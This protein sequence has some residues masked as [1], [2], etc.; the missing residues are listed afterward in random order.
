[1]LHVPPSVAIYV[2][3]R[4]ADLRKGFD[5]LSGII[6]Q[7]FQADPLDG[8]LFLFFNRRRD[9]LKILHFDG[10]GYWLYYK[11]LEAG[12]F[13]AIAGEGPRVQIDATA[14]AMLLGGVSL[15]TGT[16]GSAVP[17]NDAGV[18]PIIVRGMPSMKTALPMIAGSA[19]K[20]RRQ[21]ASL[22]T[23]TSGSF[24]SSGPNV[25]PIAAGTSIVEK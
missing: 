10:T 11:L 5:G 8:S 15:H 19:L 17:E 23:M 12:T 2:Y 13:E 14:L 22:S 16:I 6:R 4:H 20:N 25:R 9:R 3:T 24:M 7:E 1:M 21:P 18:T